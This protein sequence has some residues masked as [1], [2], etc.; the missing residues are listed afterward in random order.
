[1]VF[2]NITFSSCY[3]I[4]IIEESDTVF[5]HKTNPDPTPPPPFPPPYPPQPLLPTAPPSPVPLPHP[6]PPRPPSC[7]PSKE[8]VVNPRP[9]EISDQKHRDSGYQRADREDKSKLNSDRRIGS[10]QRSIQ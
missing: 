8:P 5:D 3:T 7:P 10:S 1:M 9:V 2:L 4:L 6:T